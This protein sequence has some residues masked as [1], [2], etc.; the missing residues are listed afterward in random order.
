MACECICEVIHC[1]A[2]EAIRA[3]WLAD[4]QLQAEIP[5][6]SDAANRVY[7][8]GRAYNPSLPYAVLRDL[9]ETGRESLGSNVQVNR[10]IRI[11]IYTESKESAILVERGIHGI[12][13]RCFNEGVCIEGG[14][15]LWGRVLSQGGG[16]V[17]QGTYLKQLLVQLF[18]S[19]EGTL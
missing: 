10:V 1:D 7:E 4:A 8:D 12:L 6:A 2:I 14:W 15:L 18:T 5:V 17:S 9:G 11:R 3:L 16:F 13:A 19:Q